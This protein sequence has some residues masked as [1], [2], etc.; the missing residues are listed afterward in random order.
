M[1]AKTFLIL[2]FIGCASFSLNAQTMK[3]D[4]VPTTIEEFVSLRDKIAKT[5][6]GGAA[7]FLLAL[8]IYVDNKELGHQCLVVA[9]D[10]SNL[11]QGNIYMG[12]ALNG[13]NLQLIETQ[14]YRDK[15]IPNSYIKGSSL[16]NGYA[17]KLPYSYEFSANAY[18]GD[19][20]TGQTKLFVTCSGAD[21]ARPITLVRND[22]GIWKATAWS[23]LVV[24]IKKPAIKDDI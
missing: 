9:S 16:E 4:M 15:N 21:S 3:I 5:P 12:F 8:K 11:A 20:A 19:P 10:R 18:S 24:G 23:S 22:K 1:N 7:L 17:V 6:E 13:Q 2:F 14:L